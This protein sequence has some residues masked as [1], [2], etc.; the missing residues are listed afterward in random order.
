MARGWHILNEQGQVTLSRQL[1]ARFD[2]SAV[3]RLS[4]GNAVRLAHQI[5]QDIWR[6][7]QNV[8]GFSPVVQ[9]TQDDG[10]LT[11]KTGGRVM[12]AVSPKLAEMLGQ[13]LENKNNRA[14]WLRAAG[15]REVAK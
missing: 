6:A 15:Y 3:T 10:G 7:L 4:G 9:I 5:R 13:V 8:R 14:R 12:G 2:V 1:P 11:V